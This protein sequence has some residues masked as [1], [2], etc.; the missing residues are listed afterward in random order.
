[1]HP[2]QVA[3][4]GKKRHSTRGSEMKMSHRLASSNITVAGWTLAFGL[5][6]TAA[7]VGLWRHVPVIFSTV[8][9][10]DSVAVAA[11]LIGLFSAVY[12]GRELYR[13]RS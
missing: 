6:A 11:I 1:M 5:L 7:G 2:S 4:I 8:R 9:Q 10:S 12:A 13:R 3:A